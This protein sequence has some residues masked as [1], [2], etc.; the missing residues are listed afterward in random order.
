MRNPASDQDRSRDGAS[1]KPVNAAAVMP[2]S[3]I[4]I[5]KRFRR[6][7]GDIAGLAASISD[8][9]LLQPVVIGSDRKLIAGERRIRAYQL[10]KR[11]SIPVYVV[12]LEKIVRGEYAENTERE[13]FKLTEAVAIK[14]AVEPLIK[15][16]AKR[17]QA[18]GGKLKGK[19]SAK[20]AGAKARPA[21]WSPSTPARPARRSQR[22]RRL[23]AAAGSRTGQPE[24][25]ETGRGDG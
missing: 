2:I 7:M 18:M 6:D 10:L 22:P 9:G 13:N 8:I 14:R 3:K 21:I 25:Q 12:D 20:L 15:A 17:R 5:G 19:A 1:Q 23:V 24:D 4:V 16:E 11:D